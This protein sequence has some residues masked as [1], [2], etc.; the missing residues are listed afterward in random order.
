MG[1]WGHRRLAVSKCTTPQ[2]KPPAGRGFGGSA[3]NYSKHNLYKE[4]M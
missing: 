2:A 3:T 1:V 4:F